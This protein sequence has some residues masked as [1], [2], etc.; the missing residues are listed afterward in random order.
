M[1]ATRPVAKPAA[2]GTAARAEYA[3]VPRKAVADDPAAY[4]KTPHEYGDILI[5]P[6]EKGRTKLGGALQRDLVYWIERHTW[7]KNIGAPAT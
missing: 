7:G 3:K 4:S 2:R 6:D 5:R 1:P